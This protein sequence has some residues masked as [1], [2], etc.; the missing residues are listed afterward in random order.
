LETK[1]IGK[2]LQGAKG[3]VCK[4]IFVGFSPSGACVDKH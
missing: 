1:K 4:S 3:G 2:F